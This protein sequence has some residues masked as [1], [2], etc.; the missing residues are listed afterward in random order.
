MQEKRIRDLSAAAKRT[1]ANRER[2]ERAERE[3]LVM[4]REDFEQLPK[5]VHMIVTDMLRELDVG[6]REKLLS[7]V[8]HVDDDGDIV[9]LLDHYS[10]ITVGLVR[11][12]LA[13]Q[14]PE[15]IVSADAK[16]VFNT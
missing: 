9:D 10:G 11:W 7:L 13:Y 4:V 8:K 15:R 5:A 16:D 14:Q 6:E 3:R 2:A 12:W 1:K